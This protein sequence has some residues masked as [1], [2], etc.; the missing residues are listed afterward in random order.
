MC[1]V[2]FEF[3]F[4]SICFWIFFLKIIRRMSEKKFAIIIHYAE[5]YYVLKSSRNQIYVIIYSTWFIAAHIFSHRT[6][7]KNDIVLIGAACDVS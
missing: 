3:I 7:M 5:Y 6:L 2:E 4:M 1:F